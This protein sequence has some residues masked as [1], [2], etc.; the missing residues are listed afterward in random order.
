MGRSISRG[1]VFSPA[2]V[3]FGLFVSLLSSVAILAVS[4]Q[5]EAA[6]FVPLR[7]ASS[8]D[9]GV[10]NIPGVGSVSHNEYVYWSYRGYQSMKNTNISEWPF[11]DNKNRLAMLPWQPDVNPFQSNGFRRPSDP[12]INYPGVPR[13]DLNYGDWRTGGG[14]GSRYV[15]SGT[16]GTGAWAKPVFL[17][18]TGISSGGPTAG[19]KQN[20]PHGRSNI[21]S[22]GTLYGGGAGFVF[23]R[24]DYDS[25]D[26][27]Y[28]AGGFFADSGAWPRD[29]PARRDFVLN[30]NGT[31]LVRNTFYLSQERYEQLTDS[32]NGGVAFYGTGDDWIRIYVNGRLLDTTIIPG[33]YIERDVTGLLRVG[34]NTIAIQVTDLA[35][36]MYKDTPAGSPGY[37]SGVCYNITAKIGPWAI[38]P[39]ASVTSPSS[40]VTPGQ[41]LT[42]EHKITNNGS[43]KTTSTVTYRAQNQ[44]SMGSDYV[45]SWSKPKGIPI[46]GSDSGSSSHI[47]TQ[48]D[49]GNNVCR[50]TVAS[51]KDGINGGEVASASAC[52]YIPYNY[53]LTPSVS[54][55]GNP[56]SPGAPIKISTSVDNAGPTKSRPSVWKLTE[57]IVGKGE[58]LPSNMDG[59]DSGKEPCVGLTRSSYFGQ[60]KSGDTNIGAV[61]N[62]TGCQVVSEGRDKEFMP[63]VTGLLP[64]NRPGGMPSLPAGSRVCYALSVQ[65]FSHSSDDWRHSK[66]VCFVVS[67]KPNVQVWGNDLRVGSA[68]S[69]GDNRDSIISGSLFGVSGTSVK[70]DLSN[71]ATSNLWPTGVDADGKKVTVVQSKA[72]VRPSVVKD[73]HWQVDGVRTWNGKSNTEAPGGGIGNQSANKG[74]LV[75]ATCQYS[76]YDGS[77]HAMDSSTPA[78]VVMDNGSTKSGK[79]EKSDSGVV[80]DDT[81]LISSGRIPWY[82]SKVASWVS[83]NVYGQNYNK[84][85]CYD[86]TYTL[87]KNGQGEEPQAYDMANIYSFSLVK[88]FDLKDEADLADTIS[89]KLRGASDDR[90]RVYV[91]GQQLDNMSDPGKPKDWIEFEKDQYGRS[92]EVELVAKPGSNIFNRTGNTLKIEVQSVYAHTGLLVENIDMKARTLVD[93]RKTY[94]SWGEYGLIAPGSQTSIGSSVKLF[95]SGSGLSVGSL[96]SNQSAWSNLT[97]SND[98]SFGNYA[99]KQNLG[100]FPNVGGYFDRSSL[101]GANIYQKTGSVTISDSQSDPDLRPANLANGSKILRVSGTVTI[102]SNLK[103]VTAP[104]SENNMSQLVII[105]DEFRISS[106]VTDVDAWLIAPNG[107]ID[108]CYQITGKLTIDDCNKPLSINGAIIARKISLKRTY[109]G[110]AN[111]PGIPAE[112]LDLRGDA[113]IWA[114]R[115]SEANGSWSTKAITELPPR[116]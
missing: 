87:V 106:S 66:V 51:P 36:W 40:V 115:L 91:N 65:P 82:Q 12:Y 43:G 61:N 89:I 71:P 59:G 116:Y 49:V 84:T 102:D 113:Y 78:I 60:I 96:D 76:F 21:T 39:S 13:T 67:K 58:P 100:T 97:F 20:S 47:I 107:S 52:R 72:G 22:C 26:H 1:K 18:W 63:S 64:F 34:Y 16:R 104:T 28:S 35:Y 88:P 7:L 3:V 4:N 114:R 109:G 55:D 8:D 95:S 79:F 32:N 110:E 33:N 93:G 44:G 73:L 23:G 24:A 37:A 86:P 111:D 41:N 85:R 45:G 38:T 11:C 74:S 80:G 46:S 42:W 48:D 81:S 17:N 90:I 31:T 30:G 83:Q 62:S 14:C 108:T 92:P 10:E 99:M 6:S 98:L 68:L 27:A 5:A 75:N 70:V 2:V 15:D 19:F 112:R 69:I 53:S 25:S 103:N 94:G 29:D 50:R 56:S 77:L 101:R 54:P 105:A 57:I 9:S